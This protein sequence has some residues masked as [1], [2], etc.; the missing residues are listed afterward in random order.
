MEILSRAAVKGEGGVAGEWRL[1]G[2]PTESE[3]SY[4]SSTHHIGG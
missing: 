3:L 4:I 1:V 2:I